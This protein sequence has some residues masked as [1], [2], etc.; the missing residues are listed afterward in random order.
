MG[1]QWPCP[2]HLVLGILLEL[3]RVAGLRARG[4]LLGG[5]VASGPSPLGALCSQAKSVCAAL[6]RDVS[7]PWAQ[8]LEVEFWIKVFIV[9]IL[10]VGGILPKCPPRLKGSVTLCKVG[11]GK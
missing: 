5:L 8:F 1:R 11:A 4:P 7:E 3:V 10:S 6:A 9:L 2:H